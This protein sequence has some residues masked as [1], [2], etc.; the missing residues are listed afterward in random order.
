[1]TLANQVALVTGELLELSA[2]PEASFLQ[3]LSIFPG[4]SGVRDA[5]G[6]VPGWDELAR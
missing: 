6:D 2:A 3:V 1:M 4:D 5:V